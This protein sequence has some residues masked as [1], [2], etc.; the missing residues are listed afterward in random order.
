MQEN[1]AKTAGEW[2]FVAKSVAQLPDGENPALRCMA[3]AG[4][5]AK[6]VSDWVAVAIAWQ[7]EF[8]DLEVA[9]HYMMEAE[10][11]AD[12][13]NDRIWIVKIWKD[14]FQDADSVDRFMKEV[15]SDAKGTDDWI[16]IAKIWGEHLQD[17]D[18][19]IRCMEKAEKVADYVEDYSAIE[20]TYR[21]CFPNLNN[22]IRRAA[23]LRVVNTI[24]DEGYF[25]SLYFHGT[26]DGERVSERRNG[27]YAAYYRFTLHKAADIA[28]DLISDVDPYLYLISGDDSTG[29]V[30]Y[31]NDDRPDDDAEGLSSTDSRIR[32][33]LS[34]GTYTIEATTFDEEERGAFTLNIYY[35]LK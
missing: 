13:S 18:N 26:W 30:L 6:D 24:D 29:E 8:N 2:V 22:A 5:A 23:I 25:D 28:I 11:V 34:T 32:C 33:Q 3:R 20:E 1:T 14:D 19:A 31:E 35:R 7:Q 16:R 9:R 17:L 4:M 10:K 27:S 15:E 12:D 21:T